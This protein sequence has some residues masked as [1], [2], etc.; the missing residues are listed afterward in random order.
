M[1]ASGRIADHEVA[2]EGGDDLCVELHGAGGPRPG[3]G[4]S[5]LC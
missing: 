2:A 1:L 5:S 3:S 4:D